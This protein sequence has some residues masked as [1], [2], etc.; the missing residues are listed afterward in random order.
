MSP[1]LQL[2]GNFELGQYLRWGTRT[3]TRRKD[4]ASSSSSSRPLQ[5]GVGQGLWASQGSSQASGQVSGWRLTP[6][7]PPSEK[8]PGKQR[9]IRSQNFGILQLSG[10]G[11]T[12]T[13]IISNVSYT[14][15]KSLQSPK[16]IL[17]WIGQQPHYPSHSHYQV[18]VWSQ[19]FR[20]FYA[21]TP[22][23]TKLVVD[24]WSGLKTFQ[25]SKKNDNRAEISFQV[26]RPQR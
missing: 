15:T 24:L 20:R 13:N 25:Y 23:A 2:P 19:V 6:S 1:R 17:F 21:K 5:G 18:V 4:K 3:P 26:L 12:I 9:H 10:N 16:G 8:A 22:K 7:F 14:Y 11:L